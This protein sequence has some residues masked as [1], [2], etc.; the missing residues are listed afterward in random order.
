[1]QGIRAALAAAVA[2]TVVVGVVVVA[3]AVLYSLCR[4]C[5]LSA[6]AAMQWQAARTVADS[7]VY[8]QQLQ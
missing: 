1:M 7:P 3:S 5:F 6:C 2:A 8:T 4:I